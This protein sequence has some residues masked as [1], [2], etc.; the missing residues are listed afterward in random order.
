MAKRNYFKYGSKHLIFLDDLFKEDPDIS[1][2]A[3]ARAFNDEFGTLQSESTIYQTYRKAK[4][5]G[6]ISKARKEVRES[7][8]LQNSDYVKALLIPDT[9]VP[10]HHQANLNALLQVGQDWNPS[11]IVQMGDAVD[12]MAVS[13]YAND[14]GIMERVSE[15]LFKTSKMFGDIRAA[16]PN[17]DE[18]DIHYLKGNHE[19]RWTR[20]LLKN[21]AEMVDLYG[22]N[23]YVDFMD[24]DRHDITYHTDDFLYRGFQ[25]I[26]GRYV[27]KHSAYAAKAHMEISNLN[28]AHGH[29]HRMGM[30]MA[31]YRDTGL[32]RMYAECGH[33]IDPD[34][35]NYITNP[36]WQAGGV[37]LEMWWPD[38]TNKP[39]QFVVNPHFIQTIDGHAVFNGKKYAG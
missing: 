11:L 6:R 10:Y 23:S 27:R 12:F 29:T 16:F 14:P 30:H 36:N 5:D 2:A 13:S 3:M 7:L 18:Q 17:R 33:L 35:A 32:P 37:L 28:G 24:L 21:A 20:Y 39:D 38:L 15:E 22:S 19:H 8:K 4:L 31:T 1:Y 25:F 26:H 9:H 34:L